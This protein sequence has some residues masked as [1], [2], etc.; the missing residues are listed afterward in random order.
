MSAAADPT[1]C[2]RCGRRVRVK[3]VVVDRNGPPMRFYSNH[4]RL[5]SGS[6]PTITAEQARVGLAARRAREAQGAPTLPAPS[7]E[8]LPSR[9]ES[10]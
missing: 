8:P 6:A 7:T 1:H 10:S 2:N 3:E 5:C 9:K 4:A